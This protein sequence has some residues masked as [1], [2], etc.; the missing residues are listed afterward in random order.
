[1]FRSAM[2]G[3]SNIQE[4]NTYNDL[5]QN[6]MGY[7]KKLKLKLKDIIEPPKNE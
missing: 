4:L 7:Y 5:V 6:L 3:T 2:D 1:M